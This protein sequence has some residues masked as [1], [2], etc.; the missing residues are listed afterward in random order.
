MP[1]IA[2]AKSIFRGVFSVSQLLCC[3]RW[4]RCLCFHYKIPYIFIID[5]FTVQLVPHSNAS[6]NCRHYSASLTNISSFIH[7]SFCPWPKKKCDGVLNSQLLL[8][9]L[10]YLF[11]STSI[12]LPKNFYLF[13]S[14]KLF[15]D[16]PSSTELMIRDSFFLHI[17]FEQRPNDMYNIKFRKNASIY[18]HLL[19]EENTMQSFEELTRMAIF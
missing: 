18:S 13:A 4:K 15:Y 19:L 10:V 16:H 17:R 6:Q 2:S 8:L 1:L 5:F 7:K 3:I 11:F 14:V 9:C 12:N